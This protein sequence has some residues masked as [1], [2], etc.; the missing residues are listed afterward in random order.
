MKKYILSSLFVT[1]LMSADAQDIVTYVQTECTVAGSQYGSSVMYETRSKW[2]VG[3]FYQAELATR[4]EDYSGKDNFLGLT[5]QA[6]LAKSKKLSFFGQL[7]SGL[8]N[9]Q[10]VVVVPG[11]ETRLNL[12]P[13]LGTAFGMSLRMGYPSVSGKIF[14]SLF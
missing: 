12:T 8:V 2:S 3:I 14:L 4:S 5:F 9:S 7:R 13:R 1:F 10:F 6:P 11:L